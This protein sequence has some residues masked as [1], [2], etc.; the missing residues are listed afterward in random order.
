MGS[1]WEPWAPGLQRRR[2]SHV[3]AKLFVSALLV[4]VSFRLFFCS[5][6]SSAPAN[7]GVFVVLP[8]D[9]DGSSSSFDDD[10]IVR[11]G[12]VR[13][14]SQAS[15]NTVIPEAPIPVITPD[16]DKEKEASK[17]EN[18]DIFNGEWIP[19]PSG[20][21][22][23]NESCRFIEPPQ[24]CM[25]NGRPDTGYLYWRWKPYSCDVPPFDAVKFLDAMRNKSW[26]LIGD[27]I[28][29]NHVQSLICLLSKAE[30]AV[31]VYHDETYKSRRW[32]FPSHN[33]TLSLIWAPFLI[34]ADIF[35]NDDG[36][37][38]SE[39]ELHLD[40]LE[41][42]WTDQYPTF[43]YIVISGGQWF[44]KTAIYLENRTVMGC[45]YCP[46]RNLTEL[47]LEYSYR[48]ALRLVFDFITS[49]P[50]KP[51]VIYRTWTP[52]HFE[53]GEW[54]SGGTCNRTKPY[55]KGEFKGRDVDHLMRG[56]ELEE[57]ER[58]VAAHGLENAG[59]LKILDTYPLS[60]LRPDGHSGPYRT[61]HPF[62]KGENLNV[63]NDCLHWCLPGPVDTWNDL[64]M[65]MVFELMKLS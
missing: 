44:L 35:E 41:L 21:A 49:S 53:N 62:D 26:A 19:N 46:K 20:P 64:I 6:S 9:R 63:Q 23:T 12:K 28:L 43:D 47:G 51:V 22:Y 15:Q 58:A 36:E 27:S 38:K 33:F 8:K 42:N 61:F 39:L 5:S 3:M 57:F 50:H 14:G 65:E 17:E 24:N 59:R 40:T 45:H 1:E 31:E 10:N 55:K 7:A 60:L 16:V 48:K 30:E 52:D 13:N 25:K 34:K 37:S 56:I 2:S 18:C 54:F 32:H 29:R 4:G 11:D